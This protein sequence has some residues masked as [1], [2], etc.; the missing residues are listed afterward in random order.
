M[1]DSRERMTP[2]YINAHEPIYS[3]LL[4]Y[5]LPDLS[6]PYFRQVAAQEIE[7]DERMTYCR[8]MAAWLPHEPHYEE[9]LNRIAAQHSAPMIKRM[10][11]S[12]LFSLARCAVLAICFSTSLCWPRAY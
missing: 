9:I 12:I 7:Q 3:Y 6:D 11:P 4:S 1:I 10:P 8:Y 5:F 2:E